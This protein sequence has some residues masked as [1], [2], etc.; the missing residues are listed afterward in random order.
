MEKGLFERLKEKIVDTQVWRSIFRHGYPDSPLNRSL[1]VISNVL[2]HIHPVKVRRKA[3]KFRYTWGMGGTTTFLF[4]V[5]AFTGIL[6]MFYYVPDVRKAYYDMKDLQYVAYFGRIIRNIHR[7]AAHGMVFVVWI[8]MLR[9]FLTGAYKPPREFN[10]II[11]VILM[12][13][14]LVLS[15]TGYLLPWDQ[16]AL[17]AITVGTKMAA[18]TPFIGSEGPFGSLLGMRI[19]N[20]VSFMLL[21]GTVVGQNALLRFY[22]LHTVVLPVAVVIF[23]AI[24]FWRIRKDGFSGPK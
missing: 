13:F 8:H 5:L 10:W 3:L 24:H 18:A 15:W 12:A 7:W 2:L 4:I 22:V 17:W 16:L 1:T 19:N 14:T 6:L 11:G 20:D 9:V 21:G 23:M